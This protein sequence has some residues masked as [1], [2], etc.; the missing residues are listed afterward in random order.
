MSD[1][2]VCLLDLLCYV[3][4]IPRIL[5]GALCYAAI[6]NENT[7]FKT[8]ANLNLY[9]AWHFVSFICISP[10]ASEFGNIFF[11]YL[12]FIYLGCSGF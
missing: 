12:L 6:P 7:N 1:L 10:A 11:N 8:F 9:K 2:K 5:R 4:E 3:R